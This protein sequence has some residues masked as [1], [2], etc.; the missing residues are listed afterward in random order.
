MNLP[1]LAV[2]WDALCAG[3]SEAELLPLTLACQRKLAE[4]LHPALWA[5]CRGLWVAALLSQR[6]QAVTTRADDCAFEGLAQLRISPRVVPGRTVLLVDYARAGRGWPT[7]VPH[8]L[9]IAHGGTREQRVWYWGVC[10]P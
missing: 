9:P 1:E 7:T 3:L 2:L 10:E 6:A 4:V 5:H 8:F